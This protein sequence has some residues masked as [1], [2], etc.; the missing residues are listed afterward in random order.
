VSVGEKLIRLLSFIFHHRGVAGASDFP[1]SRHDD[2]E[3]AVISP[4]NG[5]IL[6]DA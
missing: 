1:H 6:C 5:H 2:L 3:R 4:Q